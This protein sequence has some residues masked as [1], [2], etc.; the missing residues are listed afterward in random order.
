MLMLLLHMLLTPYALVGV[1]LLAGVGAVIYFTLGPVT[2]MK[3]ACDI[4]TWFAI[5]AVLAVLAFANVEKQNADL[6]AQ[7][8]AYAAQTAANQKTADTD[9]KTTT[10][11]RA[12]QKAGRQAQSTRLQQRIDHAPPG[13][14]QDAVL[15]GIAAERPDLAA[16]APAPAAPAHPTAQPPAAAAKPLPGAPA[17]AAGGLSKRPDGAIEP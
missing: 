2:L 16:A 8:A 15:D 6:K 5:G 9:A 12:T 7:V 17:P 11:T 10:D 3:V 14:A 13:Q 1:L 4:R